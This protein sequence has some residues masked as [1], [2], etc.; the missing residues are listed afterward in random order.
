MVDRDEPLVRERRLSH[1]VMTRERERFV[2]NQG[3]PFT[4][5]VHELLSEIVVTDWI[6][7]D[8]F[9]HQV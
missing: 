1:L 6:G 4:T 7:H 9:M 3:S 2:T 5:P 8:H